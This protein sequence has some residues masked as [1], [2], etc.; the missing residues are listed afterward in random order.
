MLGRSALRPRVIPGEEVRRGSGTHE[1][2]R[3]RPR[4]SSSR[5]RDKKGLPL[6]TRSLCLSL[7]RFAGE[8]GM[9]AHHQLWKGILMAHVAGDSHV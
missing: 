7:R 9:E 5:A 2:N 4:R 8:V 3:K 6:N 1:S